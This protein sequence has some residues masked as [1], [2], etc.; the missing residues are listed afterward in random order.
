MHDF[1]TYCVVL[2]PIHIASI[3]C[4]SPRITSFVSFASIIYLHY[5]L[6]FSYMLHSMC[7]WRMKW[8]DSDVVVR[9]GRLLP[10]YLTAT[11]LTT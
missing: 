5:L 2:K 4:P 9:G 3:T 7:V 6:T 11:R 8:E 10:C 1:T